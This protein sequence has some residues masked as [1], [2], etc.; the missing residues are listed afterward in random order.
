MYDLS[1]EMK[2]FYE[3]H[4]KVKQFVYVDLRDKKA[5]NLSRLESGIEKYNNDNNTSYRISENREQGSVAMATIVR[6]DEK[7]YDIDVAIIFDEEN[8]GEDK[9]AYFAK[10]LVYN[11]LSEKMGAFKEGPE[12]KTNCVR[13][14]YS[15]GYHIDFAVYKKRDDD[16]WHA[17]ADWSERNPK[18][19][20]DWF[21]N[22]VSEKG[23]NLRK[24]IRLSKMFCKSRTSW[25]MPGGLI[26]TV[27]CN[28]CF[29][30]NDRLDLCF[31]ST[32]V[33]VA[34]RLSYNKNVE[35][36]TDPS[37]SLLTRQ[38]DANRLKNYEN[39]L[40]DKLQ[41]F[42]NANNEKETR[43]A[44]HKFFNDDFWDNSEKVLYEAVAKHNGIECFSDYHAAPNEEFI[45][46]KYEVDLQ[47]N[48]EIN[49]IVRA[50]GFRDYTILDFIRKFCLLPHN[51]T[52]IFTANTNAPRPYTIKWKIRNIGPEAEKRN[53]QRGQIIDCDDGK[54]NQRTEHTTFYGPHYVE[55]YVIKDNKCVAKTRAYVPI[56]R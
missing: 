11:A 27:L 22:Q 25:D 41:Y 45:E 18:A 15:E 28:E 20:N 33:N 7:D 29:V 8:I 43:D 39:R 1:E 23:D 2:D 17:G 6:N 42:T 14:K 21:N 53:M 55:C 51:K 30:D 36:P 26:Q 16:Y 48:V 3:N 9:S 49:P 40:N 44:W 50:K 52:L 5:K 56:S 46:K 31:Y 54:R 19:I 37:K 10:E 32:M 12:L 4:V 47:Y 24:V 35:N 34:N 13:I 38:K